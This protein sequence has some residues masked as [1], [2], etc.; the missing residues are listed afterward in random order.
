MQR[1]QSTLYILNLFPNES[2]NPV[3]GSANTEQNTNFSCDEIDAEK[4]K[5]TI[6]LKFNLYL[7]DKGLIS[8]IKLKRCQ[9]FKD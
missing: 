6:E 5:K 8:K 1:F 3:D 9:S 7:N 4:L 2:K